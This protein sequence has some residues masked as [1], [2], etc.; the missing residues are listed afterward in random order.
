MHSFGHLHH[1]QRKQLAGDASPT[2]DH[3][4]DRSISRRR[5]GAPDRQTEIIDE[6]A[7][8]PAVPESKFVVQ[9]IAREEGG[10]KK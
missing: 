4:R 3:R 1:Q 10:G 6:V 2:N 8:P 9:L 7:A 5:E